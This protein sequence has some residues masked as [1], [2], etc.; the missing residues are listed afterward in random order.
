MKTKSALL[1]SMLGSLALAALLVAPLGC[2]GIGEPEE[3]VGEAAEALNTPVL[4]ASP[5]SLNFGTISHNSRGVTLTVTLTNN[6]DGPAS[7]ISVAVPPD[8]YRVTHNPPSDLTAGSS[9]N[10]MEITFAPT[11]VGT[12]SGTLVVSYR[13]P[14]GAGLGT[15]YTLN[16]P[17][18][19]TGS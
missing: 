19:G 15:L 3:F 4:V 11:S 13:G 12:F 2:A 7:S 9:S 10:L 14:S 16:I 17:Y 6:G 18:T 5:S 8:P 1:R